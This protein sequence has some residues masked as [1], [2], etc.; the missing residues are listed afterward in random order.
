MKPTARKSQTGSL[1]TKASQPYQHRNES[2]A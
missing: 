2:V 1:E